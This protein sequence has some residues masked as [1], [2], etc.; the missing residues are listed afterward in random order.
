[1]DI[2][3]LGLAALAG[4][5]TILSPCVIPLLPLVLGGAASEHKY[6]PLA[7]ASGLAISFTIIGLFVATVG[8]G[9]GLDTD[10]FRAVAAVL[11]I[12]VGAVLTVPIL[13]TRLAVAAGPMS[14]WTEQRLG[15]FS[16]SGLSGQFSLGILLGAVWV[17]CVGPTIGAA[18][19]LAS[20]GEDLGQVALTML[21]FGF[22]AGIPL[23][24]LGLL[25]RQVLVRWR[26]RMANAGK[27]IKTVLGVIL[28]VVGVFI[29]SGFD[30][31]LEAALV[32]ASPDWLINLTTQL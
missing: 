30:K 3:A 14:N 7:L 11:L 15:G 12:V 9:V 6:G 8:F 5:L 1:M 22:G 13:Q 27:G 2:V 31:S 21:V 4:V 20:Q 17:P 10:F 28:I 23:A 19:L 29:L 16:T 25:S 18:A 24:L 32:R 26:E